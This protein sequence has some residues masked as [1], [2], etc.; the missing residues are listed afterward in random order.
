MEVN[1]LPP[2][3]IC[4]QNLQLAVSRLG[5]VVEVEC[6]TILMPRL[7][8]APRIL[9]K[10]VHSPLCDG[11][12]LQKSE[13]RKM[14]ISFCYEKLSAPSAIYAVLLGMIRMTVSKWTIW[15]LTTPLNTDL[16]WEQ[17]LK[18]KA[19]SQISQ[20]KW[21]P[22]NPSLRSNLLPVVLPQLKSV[23]IRA[24]LPWLLHRE[25]R[26][27]KTFLPSVALTQSSKKVK[28]PLYSCNQYFWHTQSNRLKKEDEDSFHFTDTGDSK[29]PFTRKPILKK[30]NS[31]TSF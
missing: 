9:V 22:W 4:Q 1:G 8:R 14:W 5:E 3:S 30:E 15:T 10:N 28:R 19:P 29:R 6:N 27:L 24:S 23:K 18:W 7:I 26:S 11:F 16:D 25:N 12:L 21:M 2:L 13:T 17:G 31:S 20:M